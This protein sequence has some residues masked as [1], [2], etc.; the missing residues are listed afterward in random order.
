MADE[1]GQAET[2]PRTFGKYVIL[3]PL[4]SGGM[5]AVYLASSGAS[6]MEKLLA[7]K[8]MLPQLT[9]P[10]FVRRFQDEAKVVVRLSHGNLVQVFDVGEVDG[11]MYMAME[12]VEGKD[13]RAVW[14][15]CVALQ[16]AF[17]MDVVVQMMKDALRGLAY[18]HEY[19]DLHL[20]HRDIS[21]PNLLVA[22]SGEVKVADFGLAVS[23]LKMQK[24]APG[25]V[26]GK[27][28]Y[29][30]P[31][32][33]RGDA[34]DAR[35]DIYALGVICWELLTGRRLFPSKG[36]QAE[37]LVARAEGPEVP[38][39]SKVCARVPEELDGVVLRALA[40][41]PGDRYPS[42]SAMLRALAQV[43]AKLWPG[44]E[45]QRVADFM[46]TIFGERI[47]EERETHRSLLEQAREAVTLSEG[48]LAEVKAQPLL[49]GKYRIHRMLGEGAMG[50]V[51]EAE[52]VDIGRRVAV[53]VLHRALTASEEATDRFRREARAASRIRHPAVVEALDFGTTEDGRCFY[54]M[55]LVEGTS[56]REVL[57]ERGR[58]PLEEALEIILQVCEAVAAAHRA[59]VV[60]RDI[61]PGNIM[62]YRDAQGRQQVKILDFGIAKNL[63]AGGR[64]GRAAVGTPEY[65]APE[66]AAGVGAD[67]RSDIYSVAVVLY[68]LLTGTTPHAG[69]LPQEVLVRKLQRPARDIGQLRPDLP[70]GLTEVIMSALEMEPA[71]RPG[72]ADEFAA[73]LARFLARAETG[74]VEGAP[75]GRRRLLAGLGAGFVALAAGGFLLARYQPWVG[76]RARPDGAPQG[77]SA[78]VEPGEASGSEARPVRKE[79]AAP[80][81]MEPTAPR[82]ETH[83][84][85][86]VGDAQREV[87]PRPRRART[88]TRAVP[89]SAMPSRP[90]AGGAADRLR[91]A[92]PRTVGGAARPAPPRPSVRALA[93][94]ARADIL[95]GRFGQARRLLVELERLPG[96]RG[97]ALSLRALMLFQQGRYKE[98][99]RTALRA[100]RTGG[101][102]RARLVLADSYF[103][104]GL[105]RAAAKAYEEI[106]KRRPGHR[107]ARAG[108]RAA[109]RRLGKE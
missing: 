40:P 73:K 72:S 44:L 10:E 46:Q 107:A 25:L 33:A 80:V 82:L 45:I 100:V 2:Y 74:E 86:G 106:L 37:D 6:G 83:P 109:Q 12:F 42:A 98:A 69:E 39:P 53:K 32:Q 70:V 68:E 30:A 105:Y 14:N 54:V 28:G 11:Q 102:T 56:L 60:H 95:A 48:R 52:H 84:A 5:G 104:L 47:H 97:R 88:Q 18:A 62:V 59:G 108:L 51:F 79:A 103:R 94:Q 85:T 75:P 7:I 1:A 4:A 81:G 31:E 58:L 99:A 57:E 89:R 49:A 61:K 64:G 92:R 93:R 21:P 17:P 77:V 67:E 66:Q 22:Y 36:S 90:R 9:G 91:P 71:R 19:Q 23:T 26:F 24:T 16:V 27:V 8:V 65:M 87:R 34:V 96:G 3:K 35:A 38:P 29:M 101:G 13:L 20:V 41:D 15:R 43:Q 50:Q 76:W 78:R 63:G 55:E